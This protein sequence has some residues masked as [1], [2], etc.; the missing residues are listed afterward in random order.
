MSYSGCGTG[1]ARSVVFDSYRPVEQN[2]ARAMYSLDTGSKAGFGI[3]T[4][5]QGAQRAYVGREEALFN[6][7]SAYVQRGNADYRGIGGQ[8]MEV[9]TAGKV[10]EPKSLF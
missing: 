10:P 4:L 5:V 1:P 2:R 3:D 7:V 8:Y 9:P 6:D